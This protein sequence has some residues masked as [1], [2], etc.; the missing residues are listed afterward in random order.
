MKLIN[1]NNPLAFIY[2]IKNTPV[3]RTRVKGILNG[4][5]DK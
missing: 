2:Y 3:K 1:T 4:S 5:K